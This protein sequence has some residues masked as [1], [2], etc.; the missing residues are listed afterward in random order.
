MALILLL[1][2]AALTLIIPK[3]LLVWHVNTSL[4]GDLAPL[5]VAFV[6]AQDL[7]LAVLVLMVLALWLARPTRTRLWL[8]FLSLG[9][10]LLWLMLDARVRQLWL[11]P[12]DWGLLSYA[13]TNAEG[14]VSGFD[15]FFRHDAGLDLAFY[16][17]LAIVG[18]VYAGIWAAIAV[19]AHSGRTGA[20]GPP[21]FSRMMAGGGVCVALYIASLAAGDQRYHLN[22]NIL[23]RPLVE[24]VANARSDLQALQPLAVQFEQRPAPASRQAATP[25]VRLPSVAP[26]RNLVFVIYESVRWRGLDLLSDDTI[27]PN[28]A[29]MAREGMLSRCYVSVPHSSKAYYALLTG[30][31]P[32]PAIEMQEVVEDYHP[33]VF[34]DLKGQGVNTI[35]YS[36]LYLAFENMDGMLASTGIETRMQAFEL[37]AKQ[38]RALGADSSFG[39]ADSELY[40]LGVQ[41]LAKIDG[42]FAVLFFPL[43]AHYPYSCTERDSGAHDYGDYRDCLG[44]ADELLGEM[45]EHFKA[46]GLLEDTLFVIVGDHGESFGEH[47]MF[48]HNSSLFEEEVTVPAVFWSADGRMQHPGVIPSRHIDIAPTIADLFGVLDVET[49]VQGVS[50]LRTVEPQPAFMATFFDDLGLALLEYPDK[51]IYDVTDDR[52]VRY[53]LEHDPEERDGTVVSGET[54]KRIVRRLL[55]F[56]AHQRLA[57][58]E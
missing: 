46:A 5:D 7:L 17:I 14:L 57:F 15:V 41:E 6:L 58:T 51:Y 4:W 48:V 53:D 36:S 3:L 31:H 33:S 20:P 18:G 10:L 32:Y 56:R 49:P 52:L 2:L 55:A 34:H 1:A 38:G 16:Q 21:R 29:R 22:D 26:F 19:L 54:K 42:P 39:T 30:R 50:L 44:N 25:R 45:V 40:E 43:A 11:K 13:W 9:L 24:P 23:L 28:L 47:G 37:A 35:V 8:A 12:T 27:S